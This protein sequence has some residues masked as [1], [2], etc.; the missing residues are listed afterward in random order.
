MTDAF[1]FV[2]DIKAGNASWQ[3]YM[4]R[5]YLTSPEILAGAGV[6]T[7]AQQ[8][9]LT[10]ACN[11]G[12]RQVTLSPEP[13][14]RSAIPVEAWWDLAPTYAGTD[15]AL[16]FA[17]NQNRHQGIFATRART[18]RSSLHPRK[19]SIVYFQYNR[20]EAVPSIPMAPFVTRLADAVKT[21]PLK[22]FV[23]DLRFNTGGDLN[24]ATP[25]V[26]TIAPL[27][28]GTPVFVLTGR[29]TFSA[30]ITHAAQWK[31]FAGATV[32]GEPASDKLDV[33][34]EGGNIVLPNSQLTV[35][36]T[37]G[38]RKSTRSATIRH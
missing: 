3:R 38:F 35:H 5:Y 1:R 33:W 32:V 10:V 14:R 30:G 13:L 4:S 25:L 36:Y 15:P 11:D 37:N 22:A 9:P 24:V 2:R 17:L 29:A 18:T 31:Q 34:S 7:H 20:A 8:V 21:K 27:V 23:V 26:N 19:A 28:R 12:A 16:G 6:L